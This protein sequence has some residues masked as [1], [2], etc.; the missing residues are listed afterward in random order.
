[1][2]TPN[3]FGQ[4]EESFNY[5]DLIRFIHAQPDDRKVDFSEAVWYNNQ[6][7]CG[8]LLVHFGLHLHPTANFVSCGYTGMSVDD[9]KQRYAIEDKNASIKEL[10]HELLDMA[11][12]ITHYKQIKTY[13]N[14]TNRVHSPEK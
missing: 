13:L 7:T 9:N 2:T 6:N 14:S 10:I 8:C 3:I 11:P 12:R 5:D 1:M 4:I